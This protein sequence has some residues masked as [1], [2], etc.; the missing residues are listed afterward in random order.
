MGRVA[1]VIGRG[2]E[3]ILI[4]ASNVTETASHERSLEVKGGLTFVDG[5]VM[6]GSLML[7]VMATTVCAGRIRTNLQQESIKLGKVRLLEGIGQIQFAG[8]VL[9]CTKVTIGR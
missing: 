5:R 8:R 1:Y 6:I 9:W 7:L 4:E 3:E 2:A